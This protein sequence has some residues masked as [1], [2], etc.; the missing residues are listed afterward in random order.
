MELTID[1]GQTLGD[2]YSNLYAY[3]IGL[4]RRKGETAEDIEIRSKRI[5]ELEKDIEKL[6]RKKNSENQF[7]KKIAINEEIRALLAQIKGEK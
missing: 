4:T 7:N 3:V 2:I 5:R 1:T 6:E